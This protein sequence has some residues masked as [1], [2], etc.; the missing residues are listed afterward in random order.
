MFGLFKKKI[1][2]AVD[3]LAGKISEETESRESLEGGKDV[4]LEEKKEEEPTG[5]DTF[6]GAEA[7]SDELYN[8]ES[9]RKDFSEP[10][11]GA[12][13][14]L[15]EEREKEDFTKAKESGKAEKEVK[16][17]GIFSKITS[18]LT[19]KTLTLEFLD[20]ILWDME[21]VLLENNVAEVVAERIIN[22]IKL[23]LVNLSVRKSEAEQ[24]IKNTMK[25]TILEVLD[26]KKADIDE[27]I[28]SAKGDGRALLIIFLGFNGSGKTT[29]MGKMGRYLMDRGHSCVFAAAD[30]FR[31]A[32]IEQLEVHGQNLGVK[33]IKQ[34]Y[35]TDPAAI[36]FDAMKHANSKGINVVLA[37]TAGRVHTDK[38]LVEELK[39]I[40]RVNKPDLKFLVIE[41]IA[42]NDVVEQARVFD[43]AGID[44]VILTKT[45]VDEKGGSALSLC[46]TLKKPIYF[47][48]TGQKYTDFLEFDAKKMVKGIFD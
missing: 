9:E 13:S 8:E 16:K 33:V 1:K 34:K 20:E 19:K 3:K 25:E 35:G 30:S 41:S 5:K 12:E 47:I 40:V 10:K 26:I 22:D 36:I 44:G 11:R 31:A 18:P 24:I 23:K 4:S 32:A 28:R 42:G 29:T 38:N 6:V 2:E 21:I 46:Y 27:L 45:D 39:K 43:E 37:D 48:G 14:K 7:R 15:K 17:E